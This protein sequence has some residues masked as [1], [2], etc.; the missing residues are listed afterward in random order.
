[1]GR[2]RSGC[3][4]SW[5]TLLPEVPPFDLWGNPST[6]SVSF[7]Q[8]S[9]TLLLRVFTPSAVI[10]LSETYATSYLILQYPASWQDSWPLHYPVQRPSSRGRNKHFYS[11]LDGRRA[12]C[13]PGEALNPARTQG[14]AAVLS[15]ALLLHIKFATI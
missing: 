2:K 13:L 3:L 6:Y 8:A 5:Q 7:I 1:M 15:R 12:D 4:M 14:T 11:L 10:S 9:I